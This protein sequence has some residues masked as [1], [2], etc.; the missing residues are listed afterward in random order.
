MNTKNLKGKVFVTMTDSF[1]SGWGK[2]PQL[3]KLIF[4]CDTLEE[5]IIVEENAKARGD[6]KYINICHSTPSYFRLRLFENDLTVGNKFVQLKTKRS[7]SN[8]FIKDYFKNRKK[9]NA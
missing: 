2:A 1:M 7:Y 9:N 5:A 4:I 6:Q 8:W 3:N